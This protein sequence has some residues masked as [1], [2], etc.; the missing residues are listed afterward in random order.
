MKHFL[1]WLLFGL[2]VS[3]NAQ[4][5]R[6]ISKS[7]LQPLVNAV[8]IDK[9]K[10]TSTSNGKGFVNLDN[11]NKADSIKI[12]CLGY[13]PIFIVFGPDMVLS[14]PELEMEPSAFTLDEI[15]FSATRSEEKN[16]DVPHNVSVIS[17]QDIEFGNQPTSA[18][19][20]QNT[21]QVFVQKSQLGGGSPVLRGFESN[22][23]MLVVDGIRMNNA[24]YRGGHLQDVISLDPM[25]LD[26][27]EVLFGP[28]ATMYGSDALGGVMHFFTK[29]AQFSSDEKMLFKLNTYGR[30]SSANREQMGHIDFNLGWKKFASLTNITASSFGDLR[31][32]STILPGF[33]K[34]WNRNF[35]VERI[36]DKDSMVENKNNRLQA[37][38]AYQQIDIMQRLNYQLTNKLVL[39]FNGQLS[40][41]GLVPRYDRLSEYSGTNLSWAEWNY[42]PQT[43]ALAALQLK[44]T[45]SVGFAEQMSIT[46][47][48]QSVDQERI[49][50]RY[51]NNTRKTQKENVQVFGLN[52]DFK[53]RVQEKHV[54]HYGLESNYNKI[55]SK[56]EFLNIV[57]NSVSP[58]DTRYPDGGSTMLLNSIYLSDYYQVDA[59]T[60]LHGGLRFNS[61][62]LNAKFSDTTFYKFPYRDLKQNNTALSGHL[63]VT[64]AKENDYKVN[65]MGS[66]GFRA[67]NVDDLTKLNDSRAGT[68]VLVPNPELKPE[69]AY[70]LELS[71]TKMIERHLQIDISAWAT[72]LEN[73]IVVRDFKFN[74][75]DSIP[76]NG[77][78][79]KVTAMQNTDRALIYGVSGGFIASFN[80]KVSV[81]NTITYTYGRYTDASTQSVIPLDHIP[82]V[83]G[84]T[85]LFYKTKGF[86]G[87][88]FV[89]YNGKKSLKDYSPSGEDNLQYAT[90]DGMPAWFTLNVRTG[91]NVTKYF[92]FGLACENI[93][94]AHYRVFASGISA[95]G[96]NFIASMKFSF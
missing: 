82:P 73:A 79:T 86:D 1:V 65:L 34:K 85:S 62:S 53:T 57:T 2:A 90:A 56:A 39:G 32:G 72:S 38:S 92:R 19:V 37:G 4:T 54:L 7:N 91:F 43:R 8:A 61:V 70:N 35:Y 95:P 74:G 75:A 31:A 6:L 81:R 60:T 89:R 52:G 36:N 29:N 23:V 11:L 93:L 83:F 84:Q 22:K 30:F 25:M 9:S 14:T 94:D 96:R 59:V 33:D 67:P 47:S 5:I 12:S 15:I 40:T 68:Q 3:I 26:R 42:G 17:K 24:I 41:T 78:K 77:V 18:D 69:Y 63:G 10:N 46:T 58:A 76:Y 71:I 80:D 21:G 13:K 64:F 44:N 87:E 45:K 55:T 88:F 51:R 66:S 50:R 49:T 27:V 20:L 16:T 48:F 28:G